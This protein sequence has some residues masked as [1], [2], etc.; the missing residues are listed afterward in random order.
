M[1]ACVH[2]TYLRKL[3]LVSEPCALGGGRGEQ[4]WRRLL[5]KCIYAGREQGAEWKLQARSPHRSEGALR[6]RQKFSM[7]FERL[8]CNNLGAGTAM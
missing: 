8:A 1:N 3:F 7:D 4:A 2:A 5:A 6:P